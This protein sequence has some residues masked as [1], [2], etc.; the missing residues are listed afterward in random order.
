MMSTH[1]EIELHDY[2]DHNRRLLSE[3]LS[4]L[5]AAGNPDSG[6]SE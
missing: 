3:L 4:G 5:C 1:I 6:S 2:Q